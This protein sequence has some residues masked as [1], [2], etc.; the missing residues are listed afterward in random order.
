MLCF[1]EQFL[2]IITGC[3]KEHFIN[4]NRMLQR[5]RS[6]TI[7]AFSYYC[8]GDFYYSFHLGRLILLLMCVRLFVFMCVRLFCFSCALNFFSFSCALNCLCFSDLHLQYTKVKQINFT[9]FLY[10]ISDIILYFS[11]SNISV[12]W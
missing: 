6:N 10:Y 7:Y 11:C 2:S 3:Y 12:G 9:L 8:Y 1:N 4:K 5:T